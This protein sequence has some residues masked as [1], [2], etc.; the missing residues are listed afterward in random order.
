MVATVRTQAFGAG[1]GA[2]QH[3]TMFQ[4]TVSGRRMLAVFYPPL[5]VNYSV[6][7]RWVQC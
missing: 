7:V 2:R 3:L 4:S 6:A 1:T 5:P